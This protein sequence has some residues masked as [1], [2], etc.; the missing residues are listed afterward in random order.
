MKGESGEG[1]GG[2]YE[3]M[4]R[5]LAIELIALHFISSVLLNL[6]SCLDLCCLLLRL[7]NV[8]ARFQETAEAFEQV[9]QLAKKTKSDFEKIKK[10]R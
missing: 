4:K 2:L 7:D 10:E 1:R 3:L 5:L 8:E 9:R 6:P